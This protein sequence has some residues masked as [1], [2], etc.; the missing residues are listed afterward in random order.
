MYTL[1]IFLHVIVAV[2]L[3]ISV[4]MQSSKGEGL[5]GAFGGGTFSST[6]FGGRGA[7]TFL[8]RATAVLALIF[9]LT[10]VGLTVV[11]R[12]P[13]VE[14][15]VQK[16][17]GTIPMPQQQ[18]PVNVQ[19]GQDAQPTAGQPAQTGTTAK[20]PNVF[21]PNAPGSQKQPGQKSS[22]PK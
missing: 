14:S 19:Q 6:V 9:A 13:R 21:D 16:A 2:C 7:A 18:T 8:V 12:G 11:K 4:L 22:T 15:A 3:I 20:E 5:A 17:A 1:L 10:S